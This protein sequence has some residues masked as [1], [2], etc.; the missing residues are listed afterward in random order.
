MLLFCELCPNFINDEFILF[1]FFKLQIKNIFFKHFRI[2][3]DPFKFFSSAK[4]VK[5]FIFC[6]AFKFPFVFFIGKL[7]SFFRFQFKKFCK[8]FANGYGSVAIKVRR[9]KLFIER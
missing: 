2:S 8:G 3:I 4:L 9:G 7:L 6:D 5:N 1:S